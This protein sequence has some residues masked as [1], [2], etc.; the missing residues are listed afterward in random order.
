MGGYYLFRAL[1]SE[2]G[3]GASNCIQSQAS[4]PPPLFE[5]VKTIPGVLYF[6]QG[7]GL[8]L[9]TYKLLT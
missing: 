8:V 7:G 3:A 9:F 6:C 1:F 4:S 5:N 2:K